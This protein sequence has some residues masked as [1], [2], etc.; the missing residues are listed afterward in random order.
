MIQEWLELTKLT[1]GEAFTVEKVKM[2]ERDISIEGSFAVRS[3]GSIKEMEALFGISY[4]TVKNR[5][6]AISAMLPFVDVN[7]PSPGKDVLDELDKGDISVE[8]AL[9]RL[10]G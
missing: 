8:E 7:P 5:L 4:P 9:K 3:H 10:K 6:N 1:R 2:A